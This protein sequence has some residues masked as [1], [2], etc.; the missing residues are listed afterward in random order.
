MISDDIVDEYV[1]EGNS[2]DSGDNQKSRREKLGQ[3]HLMRI[4]EEDEEMGGVY[5][6]ITGSQGSGKTSVLLALQSDYTKN[7]PN[8]KCFW[9]STY[10]APLQ[11][12]KLGNGKYHIMILEGSN[13]EIRDREQNGRLVN[14]PNK[15]CPFPITYFSTYNELWDKAKPGMCNAVFFGDKKI[16]MDF[17]FFLRSKYEWAHIFIDEFSE[18]AP[19]DS[20]D[21]GWQRI[22]RF[23]EDIKEIRKC[24]KNI[25]TDSQTST[26][27]DYRV[28][29]KIMIRI[30]LPGAKTDKKT[31]VY[32]RAVDNLVKDRVNGN[33]AYIDYDGKFGCIRFRNIYKPNKEINW[34]AHIVIPGEEDIGNQTITPR[35]IDSQ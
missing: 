22:R 25:V 27:V 17:L 3:E 9:A 32:Q 23:A 2:Q 12:T 30:F 35:A 31:R 7:Y 18:V 6:E 21:V 33:M 8:D 29:R 4:I 10:N 5:V 11:F 16:W 24:N 15:H 20:K 13:V 34:E 26:D 1:S 28:R 14:F 19:S